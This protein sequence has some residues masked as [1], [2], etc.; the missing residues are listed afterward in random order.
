M[1]TLV[2]SSGGGSNFESLV[3]KSKIYK[4]YKILKLVV[5]REC[6]AIEVAKAMKVEVKLLNSTPSLND[7][8]MVEFKNF[9]LIVLAGFMP[10]INESVIQS[11]KGNIIN[12]H[13]SLLP[14]HGGLG[15]YGVKVQESVLKSKD[16]FAGCTIHQVNEQVDEGLILSQSRLIVPSGID[17][18]RLGG[19]V[20]DLERE[21]LPLT[22]HRIAKG[23]ISLA[24]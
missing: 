12:T 16:E 20:H 21:L 5:D 17:P 7:Q 1:K 3:L 8:L 6:G 18:W 11:M 13:P 10:I 24:I 22:V 15:M 19:L 23:E 4:S 14:K 2:C 9:D